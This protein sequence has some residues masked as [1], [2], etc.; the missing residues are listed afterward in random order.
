MLDSLLQFFS[1]RNENVHPYSG[2]SM[3]GSKLK[4]HADFVIYSRLYL[5]VAQLSQACLFVLQLLIVPFAGNFKQVLLL[6]LATR[7]FYM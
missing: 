2:M 7:H 4:M 5:L 1:M 6:M 3:T